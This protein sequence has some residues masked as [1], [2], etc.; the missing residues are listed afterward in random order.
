MLIDEAELV[1]KETTR[2]RIEVVTRADSLPVRGDHD[3]LAQVYGNLLDERDQVLAERRPRRGAGRR[4]RTG[5]CGSR[6]TTRA[7]ASPT[8]HQPRIFTKFFRGEARDS[9]IAGTRPRPA[10]SREIVEAHGGRIG[11]TS[12]PGLG[13][14][15]WFE[16]P[17][18]SSGMPAV[19]PS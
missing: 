8:E 13:S 7:S 1:A 18:A 6:C 15:F 14:V 19:N 5:R 3:R 2:H 9:G 10:M 16:L 11:F 17:L 4:S 12:D